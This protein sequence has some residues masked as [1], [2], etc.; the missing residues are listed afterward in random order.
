MKVALA[1]EGPQCFSYSYVLAALFSR[2]ILVREDRE[3]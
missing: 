1:L 2:I 3:I